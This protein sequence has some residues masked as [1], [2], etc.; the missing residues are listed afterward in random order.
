MGEKLYRNANKVSLQEM[1]SLMLEMLDEIDSFCTQ[2]KITYFLV[3]GSLLGAIRHNGFI[4]WDDDIDIGMPRADY[5]KF[6]ASFISKSGKTKIV[7]FRNTEQY[8][9]PFAK[10]IHNDTRLIEKD[11]ERCNIGVYIDIFPIDR[12]QGTYEDACKILDKVRFRKDIFELKYLK[13]SKN[14]NL[15]KNL[16]ILFSRGLCLVSDKY[17]INNIIKACTKDAKSTDFQ[18]MCNYL[19]AWGRKEIIE[20]DCFENVV[21]HR[22]ED[23]EYNILENYDKYLTSIYGDYMT[24]PPVEKQVS[25]HSYVAFW[26]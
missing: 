20:A 8:V 4:P 5:E 11:C 12:V 25:H 18:Y 17:L 21:R 7:D 1:K 10:A 22:F 3:G 9:W 13:I 24:P 6:V 2:H 16:G 19:G 14:R 26:R 23:R 15:L